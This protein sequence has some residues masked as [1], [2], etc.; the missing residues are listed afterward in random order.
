MSDWRRDLLKMLKAPITPGNLRFLKTWQ[1][2]EG[3][4]T[5]N[6][7]R[8]N[9]LNTT[10]DAP[11]A[12]GEINSVGV[13]SFASQREGVNALA[14]TLLN[15]RYGD[16]VKG[17]KSGRPFTQDLTAGLST[18]VSG[19]PTARP[20]YANKIMGSG[21]GT[22]RAPA[23]GDGVRSAY[24]GG[25]GPT[26]NAGPLPGPDPMA[27]LDIAFADD[28]EFLATLRGFMEQPAIPKDR[29]ARLGK[30]RATQ[31]FKGKGMSIPT[32]W[33]GTHP[34]DGLG[35]GSGTAVDLMGNPGTPVSLQ[36][37]VT[38]VYWHPTG[39]QG[40]GSMLVRTDSG[41]EYWLG[42]IANG[43]KAGTRV[44]AGRPLAVIS[45]DHPRPHVHVDRRG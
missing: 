30:R 4:H 19:S 5:H 11:G 34:T 28:P 26:G 10:M 39:A 36:E 25:A 44:R 14:A 1:R 13:K 12:T 2:W 40:G 45:S 42:H 23:G 21:P 3:G 43:R 15:G 16:I 24:P 9:W 6:E 18:W 22:R 7:A 8:Y 27:G 29:P 35:W 32:S 37:D 41:R 33:T 17:L 38:V 20:D 31:S